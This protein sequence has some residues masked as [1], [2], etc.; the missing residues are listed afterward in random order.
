MA[1]TKGSSQYGGLWQRE[2][3]LIVV[4]IFIFLLFVS[5]MVVTGAIVYSQTSIHDAAKIEEKRS[6]EGG[7]LDLRRAVE[8][9][10]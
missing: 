9:Q 1:A 10:D 7:F 3:R 4:Q 8:E 2:Q 5:L 6:I